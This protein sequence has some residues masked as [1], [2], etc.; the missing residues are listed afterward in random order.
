[1]SRID[2]LMLPPLALWSF[3]LLYFAKFHYIIPINSIS[4]ATSGA[5]AFRT[6]FAFLPRDARYSLYSLTLLVWDRTFSWSLNRVLFAM[7]LRKFGWFWSWNVWFMCRN[8]FFRFRFA[9]F[10]KM[11]GF[12]LASALAFV[13]LSL[14][15][16]FKNFAFWPRIDGSVL[17]LSGQRRNLAFHVRSVVDLKLWQQFLSLLGRRIT[18][19][20]FN[21]SSE[22]WRF[23]PFSLIFIHYLFDLWELLIK[24]FVHLLLKFL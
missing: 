21:R 17:G 13:F 16:L 14:F 12:T 18:I 22:G 23:A 15:F 19:H 24:V 2:R 7:F 20:K 8:I 10:Q 9:L 6:F 4:S 3:V 1:M 11:F 5:T